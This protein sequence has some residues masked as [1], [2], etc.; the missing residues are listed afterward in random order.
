[1]FSDTLNRWLASIKD[2]QNQQSLKA[3]IAPLFDRTSSR[4]INTAGL[5]IKAGGSALVKTGAADAYAIVKGD[6][7]KITAATDMAALVGT[8]TNAR[9]NVFCYFIDAA[10]AKTSAMGQEGANL[11]AVNFPQFPEGKALVG[12]SIVNPTGA[13]NFVGGTTPLDDATVVPNAIHLSPVSGFDPA[14]IIG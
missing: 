10:G 6:L 3:I 14:C 11:A 13:G 9:F 1:M 12:F 2:S 7:V 5:V 4:M 8:V